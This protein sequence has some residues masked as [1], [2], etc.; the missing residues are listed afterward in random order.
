MSVK[1]VK[2]KE[3]ISMSLWPISTCDLQITYFCE[4]YKASDLN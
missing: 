3:I 2:F 1:S 4:V